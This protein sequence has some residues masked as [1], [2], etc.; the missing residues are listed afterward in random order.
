MNIAAA[1]KER[2]D[3]ILRKESDVR[4]DAAVG[5]PTILVATI[6]PGIRIGLTDLFQGFSLN[7]LWLR[8]VES[9]KSALAK[10]KVSAC[11]CGF[12]LQDGTYRELVRHIRRERM[13][14]PVIIVS[15]PACPNEYGD[16]LAAMKIGALNFLSHPYRKSDL[17]K[18]LWLATETKEQ[19][20]GRQNS[21]SIIGPDLRIEEAA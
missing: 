3:G 17:E 15:S 20:I 13:D 5:K 16:F 21:D 1:L 18:M 8:G 7:A 6:D 2:V 19:A 10:Q 14:I 11:F 4:I 12:W 9:V